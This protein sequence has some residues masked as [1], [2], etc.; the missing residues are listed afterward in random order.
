MNCQ[1]IYCIGRNYRAHIT[2][3]GNQESIEPVIFIKNIGSLRGATGQVAY[4][5]EEFHHEAELVIRL[6]DYHPLNSKPGA[7]AKIEIALGIDLTR[8][9]VQSQLKA[10]G[11]P[12]TLAKSFKG[13]AIVGH[14]IAPPSNMQDIQFNLHINE[15][16]KQAGNTSL[17]IFDVPTIIH[18]ILT[19]QDLNPGDL[20]FTGT[21]EGVGPMKVGDRFNLSIPALNYEFSGVL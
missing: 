14:F 1:S 17:M 21:P 11:L 13:S 15:E 9:K 19:F 4:M 2:E 8:R 18:S 16:L 20:I 10:Q 7:T 3:L 5:T 6:M 12:W